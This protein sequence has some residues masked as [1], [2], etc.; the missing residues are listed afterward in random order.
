[1]DKEYIFGKKVINMMDNLKMI[2][3]MDMDYRF[4]LIIKD[5]KDIGK[6]ENI[7]EKVNL[8]GQMEINIKE[9]L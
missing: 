4:G 1:M 7:L 9:I 5:M 3:D 6:K 2:K 8:Y